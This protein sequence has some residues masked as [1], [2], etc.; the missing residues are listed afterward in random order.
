MKKKQTWMGITK[1]L[2]LGAALSVSLLFTNDAYASDVQ[3]S[4]SPSTPET[5]KAVVTYEQEKIVVKGG[6]E[7]SETGYYFVTTTAPK[8]TKIPATNK[9]ERTI[10]GGVDVSAYPNGKTLYFA[11]STSPA[12]EEIITVV[13]PAQPKFSSIGYAPAADANSTMALLKA[14]K[15][16]VKAKDGKANKTIQLAD[17]DVSKIEYRKKDTDYFM[18]GAKDV[19]GAADGGEGEKIQQSFPE[20]LP[21]IQKSGATLEFRTTSDENEQAVKNSDG[22]Y[23]FSNAEVVPSANADECVA[24]AF[25]RPGVIKTVK[26]T[27]MAAAPAVTIDFANH[28]FKVKKGQEYAKADAGFMLSGEYKEV[29]D[30]AGETV[31]FKDNEV[32]MVRTSGTA[33]KA[34]SLPVFVTTGVTKSFAEAYGTDNKVTVR[35]GST[36]TS[37]VMT[38]SRKFTE[39]K[40]AKETGILNPAQ[41]YQYAIVDSADDYLNEDG[42]LNYAKLVTNKVAWK[43]ATIKKGKASVDVA[44]KDT[45]TVKIVGK[46]VIL[47]AAKGTNVLS[48]RAVILTAPKAAAG[49]VAA[50]DYWT[51][52]EAGSEDAKACLNISSKVEY[53]AASEELII[54]ASGVEA[55]EEGKTV[56]ITVTTGSGKKKV[57][58][59]IDS[60]VTVIDGSATIVTSIKG[61][62]AT[63]ADATKLTIA[64]PA[65]TLTGLDGAGNAELK[66]TATVDTK[67]PVISFK[68][69]VKDKVTLIIDSPV[70]FDTVSGEE[71]EEVTLGVDK[72]A[73]TV[74]NK[75]VCAQFIEIFKGDSE[76]KEDVEITAT[77]TKKTK[78][79]L[80][81]FAMD[82]K[83]SA[84]YKVVLKGVTDIAGNAVAAKDGDEKAT[85]KDGDITFK[86]TNPTYKAVSEVKFA[87]AT[88]DVEV[89]G[90][91]ELKDQVNILPADATNIDIEWSIVEGQL[92]AGKFTCVDGKLTAAADIANATEGAVKVVIKVDGKTAEC[93]INV[94][95]PENP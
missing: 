38:I 79:L 19:V 26:V 2:L 18:N 8:T 54:N 47:R 68:S 70:K 21:I 83:S 33:K 60:P 34:A 10:D 42:T 24:G 25:L 44:L 12:Y 90:S 52:K 84:D 81:E 95:K 77:Y 62:G 67:A 66:L 80:V 57:E 82:P 49:E 3:P 72:D 20:V 30:K 55:V 36:D 58:K 51:Q 17:K 11:N 86:F 73:T 93:T 31:Y 94:T 41:S 71:T 56:K 46:Q 78:T 74:L 13:V 23:C 43:S 16:T 4:A 75:D 9:W 14:P 29:T 6:E 48:S 63:P 28:S 65:G 40:D 61:L 53:N 15:V 89:G 64:V 7:G 5:A 76:T 37:H 85:V 91:I 69:A 45:K 87:K 35:G 92:G 59:T 88:Y 27:K 39:G 50:V 32:Y 1:G 22:I